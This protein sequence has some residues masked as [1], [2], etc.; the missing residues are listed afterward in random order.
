M[1]DNAVENDMNVGAINNYGI[2]NER[3][4]GLEQGGDTGAPVLRYHIEHGNMYNVPN[5]ANDI[6]EVDLIG[7]V[8]IEKWVQRL[9][10]HAIM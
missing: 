4:N 5:A 6:L 9:I 10:I 3:V 1:V 2:N 8:L 7:Q